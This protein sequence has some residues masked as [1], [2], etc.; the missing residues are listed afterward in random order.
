MSVQENTEVAAS[1]DASPAPAPTPRSRRWRSPIQRIGGRL[2][3]YRRKHLKGLSTGGTIV[4][5]LGLFASLSPSLLPRPWLMQGVIS[6]LVLA[7]FYP[8]GVLI[9]WVITCVARW[10]EFEYSMADR[11]R[12]TLAVLW[13]VLVVVLYVGSQIFSLQWQRDAARLVGAPEPSGPYVIA[14]LLVTTVVFGV[15]VLGFRLVHWAVGR[16]DRI[17]RLVLPPA[18]SRVVA[19]VVAIALVVVVLDQAVLSN[20]VRMVERSSAQANEVTPEG[21]EAPTS[22]LRSGGPGSPESWES[23]GA[24]GAQFVSSGPSS[25][26]ITEVTGVPALEPIRVYAGL[27]DRTITQV[28]EAVAD[29]MERTGAFGRSAILLYTTT[30]TGWVNEWSVASFEYLSGGDT[31][32]AAMQYSTFPSA[33]ALLTDTTTPQLAGTALLQ[34]VQE[35]MADIP[36]AERPKLYAAGESLGSYGG[37]SAFDNP[38]D[39]LDELDGAVWTGTPGFTELHRTLTAMRTPGSTEVNPVIDN[40]LHFRFV[41]KPAELVADQFGRPL[42]PWESPRIAYVQHP[43]DPVVWWSMDLAFSE[44]GWMTEPRGDDVT[45]ELSYL[46]IA[47][48][49]QVSA[50]MAV[51]TNVDVGHGHVY[52]D[53]VVPTWAGV[54][55]LDPTADYSNVIDAIRNPD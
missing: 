7:L 54:L 43:S 31:A 25:E 40:G 11:A 44:P 50:D 36:E 20:I 46:P 52:R 26:Q 37:N 3:A 28:A 1:D 53:E 21:L 19:T 12:R 15:I 35:R 33:L 22:T 30:G 16:I 5:L 42:G 23:L 32:V 45:G 34:A 49:L 51:A 27:G 14:S 29:E 18:V 4:A 55:G 24:Q 41:S 8:V 2:L 6:G 48:L 47:T 13:V 9:E 17:G 39:M 10:A 38:Q